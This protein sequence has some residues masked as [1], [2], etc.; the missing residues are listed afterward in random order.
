[1]H[2]WEIS[3]RNGTFPR[4]NGK[5]PLMEPSIPASFGPLQGW[6]GWAVPKPLGGLMPSDVKT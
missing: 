4:V 1:M 2:E 5:S 6:L 3:I